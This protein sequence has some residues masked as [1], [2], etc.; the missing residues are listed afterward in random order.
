MKLAF[1]FPGQGSQFVGMGKDLYEEFEEVRNIYDK[2]SKILGF[3]IAKL[4]FESSEE[5]L[6]ETQNTQITILVMCL[7]ILEVLKKNNI[8]ADISAGLSLGEYTALMYSDNISFE[9]GI[10][11]VR[12]RGELMQNCV[13]E[14]QWS[15]AAVLGLEDLVVETICKQITNHFV[16]PA[17]YNCLGQVVV[18]GD[19]EGIKEVIEKAKECGAKRVIELKTSGPFHTSKLKM[20]SDKLR[21][22]LQNI[23]IN[24][25]TKRIVLKNIDGKPYKTDDDYKEILANHVINPVRFKGTVENMIEMG[26]DTFVEIGPGKTLAGFVKKVNKEVA[27]INI[28]SVETLKQAIELLKN[29]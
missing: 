19:K 29:K 22:E 24:K 15:M 6:A 8:Q 20:A 11:I 1:V 7:G 17:N 28:N 12:K 2:A 25:D 26:A 14:G 4:T 16:V 9:D 3:D 27:T 23:T 5:K 10:N 13:P 21:E 18:S